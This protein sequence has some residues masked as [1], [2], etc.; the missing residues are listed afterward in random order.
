MKKY[1][2]LS[3]ALLALLLIGC[4]V[5]Q[6]SA[7]DGAAPESHAEVEDGRTLILLKGRSIEVVGAGARAS[8]RTVTITQGGTYAISGTL[9]D[10]QIRVKAGDDDTVVLSLNDVEIS[11]SSDAAIFVQ[12][13]GEAALVLESG[14]AN[15]VR[16][17]EES[18]L[19]AAPDK[20]AEGA[21]VYARDDLSITG[22]GSL[23]V[24]GCLNNGIHTTNRLKIGGG[25]IEVSARNNAIKGKDAVTI[26][27]GSFT[28][29]AGGDGIKSDDTTG[30]G[31]GVISISG[32]D[33]TIEAGGDAVQSETLL[34]I[35]R[36]SFW[37]QT[38]GGSEKA[39]RSA[40]PR[41]GPSGWDREDETSESA[42]GFKSGADMRITGGSF[43]IDSIDDAF[44]SDGDI[45]I[46]GGSFEIASGDDGI[47]ADN[48]LTVEA[49][50]IT[51]TTSYEGMEANQISLNGGDIEI[52][53]SDD[54][55]NAYGGQNRWGRGSSAKTTELPPKLTIAGANVTINAEGDGLDSNADLYME[56]GY[57]IVNGPTGNMN[58]ALDSG[59]ENGG[60]CIVNGGTILAVGSSG[61][62]EAFDEES[63][64]YSFRHNFT[65]PFSAGDELTITDA[66][67]NVLI[68]HMVAKRA[69]SVVFSSPE[70]RLG[71][72][73]RLSVG[74]ETTEITLT[75]NSTI[76]GQP[77]RWGW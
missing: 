62:A 20:D 59:S 54:G 65:S 42:K 56:S 24:Y 60:V 15:R 19:N 45:T 36:G 10:G 23:Q 53:S 44:H 48:A 27:D 25:T 66:R 30:E 31:F 13:V 4:A 5:R 71:E 17:G 47:H 63:A 26:T 22:E 9:E 69:S 75:S 64:Q 50:T 61:M 1:I 11:N 16:S 72:T 12:N 33:F 35:A 21:A 32:G 41:W 68:R 37:V 58:G 43:F 2:L 52:T 46:R 57:V 74:G 49:G 40:E 51:I 28:L 77:L 6:E 7:I 55:I 29:R 73:Y 76:S 3:A 70:L 18:L 39:N 38:G 34:E 14:T 8:G 67:G